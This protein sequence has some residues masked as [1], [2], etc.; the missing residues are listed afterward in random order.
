MHRVLGVP[1][2]RFCILLRATYTHALQQFFSA[3]LSWP[4]TA[5]VFETNDS[6]DTV[7]LRAAAKY[8]GIAQQTPWP[9]DFL[10]VAERAEGG[11]EARAEA[12]LLN[13]STLPLLR[14]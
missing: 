14:A 4:G 13:F 10:A 1:C 7:L 8:S 3:S 5:P 11:A 9:T 6:P 2:I 12:P